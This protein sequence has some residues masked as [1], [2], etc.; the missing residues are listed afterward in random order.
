[1]IA[2]ADET[3]RL[4]F[5]LDT[6]GLRA[7]GLVGVTLGGI[8]IGPRGERW[9]HPVGKDERRGKVA[10]LAHQTNTSDENLRISGRMISDFGGECDHPFRAEVIRRW[11]TA[12][13]DRL[14]H[15]AHK[16]SLK[17]ESMRK[18]SAADAKKQAS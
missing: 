7:A 3:T 18:R 2:R 11:L 5:V 17:G 10:L 12:S 4:R 1:M 9:L 6:T 14:V 15:Q 16:V 8:E 13:L